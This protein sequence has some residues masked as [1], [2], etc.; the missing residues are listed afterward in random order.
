MNA[1]LDQSIRDSSCPSC[2]GPLK[3]IDAQG[4]TPNHWC[5]ACGFEVS[6]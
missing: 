1:I 3:Q 5:S 6:E 4:L 2:G